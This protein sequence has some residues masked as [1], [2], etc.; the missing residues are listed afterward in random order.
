MTSYSGVPLVGTRSSIAREQVGPL[1]AD[2]A[3]G[4][5]VERRRH[6]RWP[7]SVEKTRRPT[8]SS[9]LN[10]PSAAIAA[11]LARSS[12]VA[13]PVLG[14]GVAHRARDVDDEQHPRRL[15]LLVPLVEELDRAPR[16]AGTSSSVCGWFG[17][18]PFAAVI[19]SPIATGGLPGRKPNFSTCALV[20][21]AA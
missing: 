10:S 5:E 20:A 8:S 21:R 17:S 7:R 15:A 4:H 14:R 11:C 12:F 3:D 18:T 19:G 13:E 2:R 1:L 16:A 6:R 9:S